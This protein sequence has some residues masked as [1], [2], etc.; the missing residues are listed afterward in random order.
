VAGLSGLLCCMW[1]NIPMPNLR[2]SV[3][4][5]L[6]SPPTTNWQVPLVPLACRYEPSSSIE[7]LEVVTYPYREA[8]WD[9]V[10]IT[11]G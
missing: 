10:M 5:W 6:W 1:I 9:T 8:L 7:L 2:S 3:N 4:T 11:L